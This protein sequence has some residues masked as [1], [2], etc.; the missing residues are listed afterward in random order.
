LRRSLVA[1]LHFA[2]PRNVFGILLPVLKRARLPPLL[3][4][5]QMV[6]PL[7]VAGIAQTVN[8][9]S[10]VGL[11]SVFVFLELEVIAQ[12]IEFDVPVDDQASREIVQP[13]HPQSE[14]PLWVRNGQFLARLPLAKFGNVFPREGFAVLA[15]KTAEEFDG[16]P[17]PR[18]LAAST[19]VIGLRRRKVQDARKFA[20][21]FM[22]HRAWFRLTTHAHLND[23]NTRLQL[24]M[25]RSGAE[26]KDC[27]LWL[28]N[29]TAGGSGR[30]TRLGRVR[31][32]LS[33]IAA[34]QAKV[35]GNEGR[36]PRCSPHRG[37]SSGCPQH[38]MLP[39]KI[40]V[41]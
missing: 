40:K 35:V 27:S 2:N 41:L 39:A 7:V 4:Q 6:G 17:P 23:A 10:G 24:Y 28:R 25:Q 8:R 30:D 16:S 19:P 15:L 5:P 29:T 31:L 11:S 13:R 26:L 34:G 20:I 33:I 21:V 3:K 9:V 14:V 1:P 12:I 38:G 18:A 36:R 37:Q 32:G 22:L